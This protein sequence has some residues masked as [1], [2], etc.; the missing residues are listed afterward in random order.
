MKVKNGEVKISVLRHGIHTRF[1]F[2]F[3]TSEI[4]PYNK[5]ILY[6]LH[7]L[8]RLL[9]QTVSLSVASA[10]FAAPAIYPDGRHQTCTLAPTS[11]SLDSN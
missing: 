2:L 4:R 11:V 10:G 1:A 7:C 6:L 9:Q 5:L 3:N 8:I